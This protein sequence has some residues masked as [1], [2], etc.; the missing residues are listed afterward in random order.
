MKRISNWWN[1]YWIPVGAS[2]VFATLWMLLAE[3]LVI[4]R[5]LSGT[6]A[7]LLFCVSMVA[8]ETNRRTE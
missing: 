5:L 7:F 8:F 4:D 6:G 3:T 1:K 2:S